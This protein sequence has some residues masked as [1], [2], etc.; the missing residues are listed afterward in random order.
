VKR[1]GI[2][3][4][5][6]LTA[7]V[8]VRLGLWQVDRLGQRKARNA[9]IQERQDQAPVDL[10]AGERSSAFSGSA[11]LHYRRATAKGTFDFERE[12]VVMARVH[13]GVPGAYVITPLLMAGDTAVL[14]ERG[15]APAPDGR[16]VE[17]S[18]LREPTVGE[19][20]GVLMPPPVARDVP[21]A[22][23]AWP[24]FVR[25]ANPAVLAGEYPY[26]LIPLVLRR[27]DDPNALP[28]TMRAVPLPELTNGPHLSY[29][30][31]WFS[32][33]TIA[34]IGSIVLVLRLGSER[35]MESNTIR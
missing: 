16:G 24:R 15:W 21:E 19:V 34:V 35:G 28:A 31:Q 8:C 25:E 29:A 26:A 30:L 1:Y 2:L 7:A 13:R 23:R 10:L 18:A 11:L 5:G 17:L 6:V 22:E 27:T 9:L 20:Q 32:F 4:V 3:V 33:A 12:V 14:V